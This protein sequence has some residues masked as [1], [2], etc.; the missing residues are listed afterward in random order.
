MKLLF[1]KCKP[2]STN[3]ATIPGLLLLYHPLHGQANRPDE[4]QRGPV[5]NQKIYYTKFHQ[6]ASFYFGVSWQSPPEC[7][8]Y[9]CEALAKQQQYLRL[10]VWGLGAL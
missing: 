4:P 1:T 2:T 5:I 8:L 3:E 7:S 6:V 9:C 10:T